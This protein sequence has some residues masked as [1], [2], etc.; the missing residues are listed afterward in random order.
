MKVTAVL[1]VVIA[2]SQG[3][4]LNGRANAVEAESDLKTHT[5]KD[6]EDYN[7]EIFQEENYDM[8]DNAFLNVVRKKNRSISKT[9]YCPILDRALN[10]AKKK[11]CRSE[12][13][14]CKYQNG[15]NPLRC[16]V[17]SHTYTRK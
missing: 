8:S 13:C 15:R 6:V 4:K 7:P 10:E 3:S 5:W 9:E 2:A 17:C 16:D 1:L 14:Y 12:G 11:A